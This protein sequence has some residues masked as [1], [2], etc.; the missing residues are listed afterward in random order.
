MNRDIL[1]IIEYLDK[2]REELNNMLDGEE[3]MNTMRFAKK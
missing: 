3:Y 2:P 1:N